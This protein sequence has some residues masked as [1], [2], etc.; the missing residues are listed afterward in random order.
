MSIYIITD[1]E[2]EG[3]DMYK[4]GRTSKTKEKILTVYTRYLA[5][6]S[7]K[8]YKEVPESYNYKNIEQHI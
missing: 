4:I 2:K 6:A 5:N 8:F 1:P 3:N 7:I